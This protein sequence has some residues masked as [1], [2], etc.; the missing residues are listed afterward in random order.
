MN[1]LNVN[2]SLV[3]KRSKIIPF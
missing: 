1:P 2:N 3:T